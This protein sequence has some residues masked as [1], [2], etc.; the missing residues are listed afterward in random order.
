MF[1]NLASAESGN[2]SKHTTG[3]KAG[4]KG[5]EEGNENLDAKDQEKL[6]SDASDLPDAEAGDKPQATRRSWFRR[7][8]KKP[9][10]EPPKSPY[11][12]SLVKALHRT[13]FWRW[14]IAGALKLIGGM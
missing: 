8:S 9:K 6:N 10:T 5:K 11:D 14:W 12:S 7:L 1:D 4:S 13:F 3:E 2:S